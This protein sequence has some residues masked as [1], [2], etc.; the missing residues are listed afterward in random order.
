MPLAIGGVATRE[1]IFS[2]HKVQAAGAPVKNWG[3]VAPLISFFPSGQPGYFGWYAR[4][5][6]RQ[7]LP[8]TAQSGGLLIAFKHSMQ[9]RGKPL[10]PGH[11]TLFTKT[12]Y[13]RSRSSGSVP[14]MVLYSGPA[15]GPGCAT[16]GDSACP[17]AVINT[18][19]PDVGNASCVLR[20]CGRLRPRFFDDTRDC[21]LCLTLCVSASQQHYLARRGDAGTGYPNAGYFGDGAARDCWGR[22]LPNVRD[23]GGAGSSRNVQI[24]EWYH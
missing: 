8:T 21:S 19:S 22:E 23:V 20:W 17:G 16:M 3:G 4:F 6:S 18:S 15:E 1:G 11:K 7:P 12:I 5:V 13:M 14:T 10:P 24:R 9:N 2:E